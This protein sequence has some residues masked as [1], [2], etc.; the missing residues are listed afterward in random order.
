MSIQKQTFPGNPNIEIKSAGGSGVFTNYIFKAIPLAFDESMSYYETLCGLLYYLKNTII[1]V[2]NNNAEAVAELQKLYIELHDYVENYFDNL[3]VQEEINNKLDKM[4]E[5]GTF[6]KII[7]K[8]LFNELNNKIDNINENYIYLNENSED[9]TTIDKKFNNIS[10]KTDYYKNTLMYILELKN[11]EK[12]ECIPTNGIPS[13]PSSNT[14]NLWDLS[15]T[16]LNFDLFVNGGAFNVNNNEPIGYCIFNGYLYVPSDTPSYIT[17]IGFDEN[18]N[19]INVNATMIDNI[20]DLVNLG[21]KNCVGGF[22]NLIQNGVSL[23]PTEEKYAPRQTIAQLN[24]GNY[25][26]I[27]STGRSQFNAGLRYIDIIEYLQSH[28]DVKNAASLDG[29]GSTQTFYNKKS[30][31]L[32]IDY[33]KLNGRAVPT[34]LGIKFKDE[35]I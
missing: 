13:N 5:D 18:N 21:M 23:A 11:I 16:N 9:K 22:Q 4:V 17:Y 33:N 20:D 3:D 34:A 7:N 19:L 31:L 29:G 8:N 24:N 15:K 25:V 6:D 27:S 30:I 32:P 2:V 14:L 28:Y 1:P 35:V 12:I 26:I 10:I